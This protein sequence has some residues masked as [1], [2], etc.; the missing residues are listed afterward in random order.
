VLDGRLTAAGEIAAGTS[1]GQARRSG[2]HGVAARRLPQGLPRS[3]QRKILRGDRKA[4]TVS[5]M[6]LGRP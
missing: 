6:I 1:Q 2:L 4:S 3:S 5:A